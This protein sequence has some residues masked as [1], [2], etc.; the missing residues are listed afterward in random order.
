[1]KRKIKLIILLNLL[2]FLK[3]YSQYVFKIKVVD[4]I[5]KLPIELATVSFGSNRALTNLSGEV[6]FKTIKVKDL[7]KISYLGYVPFS[8][9]ISIN[10]DT[11]LKI[12]LQPREEL[13]DEIKIVGKKAFLERKPDRTI[14]R[15]SEKDKN[16][17]ISEILRKMPFV[18]IANNKLV[19]KGKTNNQILKDGR[20]SNV[21]TENLMSLNV[22]RIDS[23]EVITSPSA[24]Y[25]G[26]Y[27]SIVNIIFKKNDNFFGGDAYISLGTRNSNGGLI[28]TKTSS[29]A[30]SNI[31]IS[32]GYDRLRSGSVNE[33]TFYETMPYLLS[34]EIYTKTRTSSFSINYGTEF[35]LK[36]DQSVSFGAN[37]DYNK[38][39]IDNNY[40]SLI[41]TTSQS[42]IIENLTT[43]KGANFGLNAAYQKRINKT[44]KFYFTNLLVRNNLDHYLNS[45]QPFHTDNETKKTEFTTRLDYEFR[46]L[47]KIKAE[48][49][50]KGL[51]RDY[52]FFPSYNNVIGPEIKFKQDILATYFSFSRNIKKIYVRV[53]SRLELTQN[54]YTDTLNNLL[55]FLP[56]ILMVYNINKANDISISFRKTLN[57]PSFLLLNSFIN[58]ETPNAVSEGNPFLDNENLSALEV[59]YDLTFK[60]INISLSYNYEHGKELIASKTISDMFAIK[61]TFFGNF[62]ESNANKLS[63]NFRASFLS[64]KLSLFSSGSFNFYSTF[65]MGFKNSGLVKTVNLGFEY[66]PIKKLS[67]ELFGNYL[68]NPILLQSKYGN[69]IF[70]DFVTRYKHKKS[71]FKIQ[72]TNPIINKIVEKNTNST[73]YFLSNGNS[74][75]FG[76]A[77]SVGYTYSFGSTKDVANKTRKI[78]NED[79]KS[80]KKL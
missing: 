20:E 14:Y 21:S 17:N 10:N 79:I 26:E 9:K 22:N 47:K 43:D 45:T 6:S 52:E 12:I 25:D 67:F 61:K 16:A 34:Q 57:R 80:T 59:T 65:G 54:R 15:I 40:T 73:E 77:I 4:S 7:I 31:E 35:S 70:M 78:T 64:D 27:Q 46:F 19:I 66:N 76:R 39:G 68:D 74:Y 41:S 32:G 38:Y 49:G 11:T 48:I 37:I 53:G 28:L 2:F 58:K 60:K 75:Y 23:I 56:N 42:Q 24:K 63:Y 36:K 69:S 50:L 51:L 13:L 30:N 29:S 3:G 8:K 62:T 5:Y 18:V 1:M 55:N 71:S 33:T 72:F 44:N